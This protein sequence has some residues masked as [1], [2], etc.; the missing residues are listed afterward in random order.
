MEKGKVS[1]IIPTH[2]GWD[3]ID[4]TIASVKKQTYEKLEIIVVDSNGKGSENQIKTEKTIFASFK[5]EQI[6][7]VV[8][9]KESNGSIARNYGFSFSEGE[10]ICFLDDDDL[11]LKDKISKEISLIQHHDMIFCGAFFVDCN[12]VGFVEKPRISKHFLRDY[13]SG[14]YYFNT[15]T[16]LIKRCVI[17]EIGGFDASF[18][19]HQDWEFCSR[20]ISKYKVACLKE[21]LV[22]KVINRRN[23]VANPVKIEEYATHLL[24]VRSDV[25]SLMNAK[26]KIKV[27]N[28]HYSR[29]ALAYYDNKNQQKAK[30]YFK[31]VCNTSM[32]VLILFIK[33]LLKKAFAFFFHRRKI[34]REKLEYLL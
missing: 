13:L 10:F 29:I 21:P 24:D 25:I 34:P 8:L 32:G 5:D 23:Y 27:F 4:K 18:N 19:R 22:I 2:K 6:K 30:Q 15:S 11:L 14:K 16:L 26:D 1:I 9:D 31:L 7:Y 3:T 28:Y 17:E 20:I 33:R 12:R